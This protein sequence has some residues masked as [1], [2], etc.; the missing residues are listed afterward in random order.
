MNP[1]RLLLSS[2]IVI[3]L[4]L[5]NVT[6][7]SPATRFGQKSVLVGSNLY[8]FGGNT[9]NPRF[10]DEVLYLNLLNSF[11]IISPPWSQIT[12]SPIP[13]PLFDAMPCLSTDGSTVYLVGGMT[14]DKQNSSILMIPQPSVYAFNTNNLQW[15]TPNIDNFN[16]TF[17]GR[18]DMN[19]VADS[20][21]KY[22]FFGGYLTNLTAET[23]SIVYNDTNIFDTKAMR[24]VVLK[25]NLIFYIGGISNDGII[26]MN[27][28]PSFDTVNLKWLSMTT[29][30]DSIGS[31]SGHSTVLTQDG[32]IL[33]YGGIGSAK[34]QVQPEVA[35]LDVGVTPYAWKAITTNNAPPQSL[36]YHSAALYGIYMIVA[37]GQIVTSQP[38]PS[39]A[40]LAFNT[41]LYILNT[42]NYT[43]VNTFDASNIYGSNSTSLKNSNSFSL[44]AK[45]G[46]G[47]GVVAAIGIIAVVGFFLYKKYNNREDYP[48]PTPGS[49]QYI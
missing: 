37:F 41:N 23:T 22:Y 38:L 29:R 46:I 13:T 16:N 9:K 40:Q 12:A 26:D 8:F 7:F 48:I 18:V 31:R 30:G 45:I 3:G 47:I 1:F 21:G 20:N 27:E 24:C 11:N 44:G 34:S 39:S 6:C 17:L 2:L 4:S 5:T 28:I 49:N 14:Q 32:L 15:T 43:W 25:D 42:K 19:G 35:T 36:V 10:T 33:I